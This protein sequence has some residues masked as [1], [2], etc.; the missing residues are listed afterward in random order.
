MLAPASLRINDLLISVLTQTSPTSA[1]SANIAA[2]LAA[3]NVSVIA[4]AGTTELANL[5]LESKIGTFPELVPVLHAAAVPNVGLLDK[6]LYEPLV[7]T[8]ARFGLSIK[9]S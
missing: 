4:E 6:S 1:E 9:S 3:T 5:P 2:S 8:V 7:A